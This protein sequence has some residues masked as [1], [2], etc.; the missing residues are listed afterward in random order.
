MEVEY[1]FKMTVK[2]KQKE[3]ENV[4]TLSQRG[5][6]ATKRSAHV[7][8]TRPRA[9]QHGTAN[10]VRAILSARACRSSCGR[11]RLHS[12]RFALPS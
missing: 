6:A 2:L 5:G 4:V 9:Q 1:P 8:G 11:R 3:N 7:L 10:G 12:E